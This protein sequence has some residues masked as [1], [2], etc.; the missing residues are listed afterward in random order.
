M[1]TACSSEVPVLMYQTRWLHIARDHNPEI[2]VT[3]FPQRE[4]KFS[5]VNVAYSELH[6]VTTYEYVDAVMY[7][8]EACP[9]SIRLYFFPEKP[10][11]AGWQI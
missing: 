3:A 7:M 9:K 1:D 5:T 4:L 2:L 10:V 6:R 11:T 8:Y